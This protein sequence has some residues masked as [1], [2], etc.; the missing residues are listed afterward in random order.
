MRKIYFGVTQ[1]D[2]DTFISMSLSTESID[3]YFNDEDLS[4]LE[5]LEEH[6]IYESMEGVYQAP[7]G[8]YSYDE[9][10]GLLVEEGFIHATE[11]DDLIL[12]D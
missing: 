11:L 8:E 10:I 12:E 7:P 5:D 9:I 6:E 1:L 3:N 2:G 4:R